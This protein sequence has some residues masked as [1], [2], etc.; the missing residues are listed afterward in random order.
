MNKKN[1]ILIFLVIIS[2]IITIITYIKYTDIRE[3]INKE[4]N[5]I[6]DIL[7]IERMDYGAIV[8]YNS[9]NDKEL[10]IAYLEKGILGWKY[11]TGEKN[12]D[13][14]PII[15]KGYFTSV[16]YMPFSVYYGRIKNDNIS[17]IRLLDYDKGKD[18]NAKIITLKNNKRIWFQLLKNNHGENIKVLGLSKHDKKIYYK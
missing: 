6:K 11:K 14:Y 8:L 18:Y 16:E 9:L 15:T 2:I 12:T 1:K 4:N 7:H 10:C 13:K 3:A 17:M 5:K